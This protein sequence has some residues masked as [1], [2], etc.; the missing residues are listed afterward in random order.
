[1]A[2]FLK[3]NLD[4][5]VYSD[6]IQRCKGCPNWFRATPD[7]FRG[8][9]V[10]SITKHTPQEE[11]SLKILQVESCLDMFQVTHSEFFWFPCCAAGYCKSKQQKAGKQNTQ[12]STT[13]V[14]HGSN[15]RAKLKVAPRGMNNEELGNRST[16][17]YTKA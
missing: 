12:G 5:N 1:V 17:Q 13:N 9:L 14:S 15:Y 6:E 10:Q 4:K 3:A 2:N 7:Q 8:D 11:L 16:T